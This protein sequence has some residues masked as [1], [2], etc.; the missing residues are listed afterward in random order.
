MKVSAE[1]VKKIA[2]LSRLEIK[3]DRVEAVQQQLS[4]ILSYMELIEQADISEVEPTAHA[5]SMSNVMRDDVPQESLPNEDA[6]SYL[7]PGSAP[8]T[9]NVVFPVTDP[10]H[11]PPPAT[12]A[13]SASLRVIVSN[14]PVRTTTS[15]LKA[16]PFVCR[17]CAVIST[18][19]ASRAATSLRASSVRIH[20]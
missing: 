16:E 18:P 6:F 4:D 12:T 11:L 7:L 2:L 20:V 8:A 3:E 14:L 5:V 15:P 10:V 1:E 17:F 9:T 19:A 13:S